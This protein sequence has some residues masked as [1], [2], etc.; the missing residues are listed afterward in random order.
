[1]IQMFCTTPLVC[2][3]FLVQDTTRLVHRPRAVSCNRQSEH[4]SRKSWVWIHNSI[5]TAA[6]R[7]FAGIIS[8][9][10]TTDWL[11]LACIL[12]KLGRL[13]L[14]GGQNSA[15]QPRVDPLVREAVNLEYIA[16]ILRS[17]RG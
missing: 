4:Y 17:S 2:T 11:L 8:L 3:F 6:N 15:T 5:L 7:S 10:R 13:F 16:S 9:L 12:N 1:M 14:V